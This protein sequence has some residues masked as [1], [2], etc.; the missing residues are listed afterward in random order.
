M[1]HRISPIVLL[2]FVGAFAASAACGLMTPTA[3]PTSP[4]QST[5]TLQLPPTPF[6]TATPSPPV[7]LL[8]RGS[9]TSLA[10][11]TE[12]QSVLRNLAESHGMQFESRADL[13]PAD[14]PPNLRVLILAED[15]GIAA[16]QQIQSNAPE[17][18]IVS[19]AD[20]ASG[21]IPGLIQLKP[22][23][24]AALE[25]AFLAG[26]TAALITQDYRIAALIP[27]GADQADAI[28]GAFRSGGEYYC[29]LCRTLYP[30]YESYPLAIL[31]TAGSQDT[32]PALSRARVGTVFVPS[33]LASDGLL[34]D[35]T[36]SGVV[37]LGTDTPPAKFA[38]SWAASYLPSPIDG[39][40]AAWDDIVGDTPPDSISM[41][42]SAQH[43]NAALLSPGRLRLVDEVAD[44]IRL[45]FIDMG[46][47][48]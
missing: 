13:T 16:L 27:E 12:A 8:V 34:T 7:V 15:P 3:Q 25:Q 30:P 17:A 20:A 42:I 31:T 46:G 48:P 1:R 35:L 28:A 37:L 23:P 44:D 6:P 24:D 45:G 38:D 39:I 2:L 36:Q 10:F 4:P 19:M 47:P 29:G 32:L 5:S 43:V 18:R 41:P 26:Y 33:E 21:A 22:A 14:L 40:Q 11:D 9:D